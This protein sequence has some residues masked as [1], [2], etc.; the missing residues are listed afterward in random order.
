[1]TWKMIWRLLADR[2]VY[3][4]RHTKPFWQLLELF[5]QDDVFL[6]LLIVIKFKILKFLEKSR[7]KAFQLFGQFPHFILKWKHL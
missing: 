7:V 6:H 1:M 4:N 5:L 3:G 2:H